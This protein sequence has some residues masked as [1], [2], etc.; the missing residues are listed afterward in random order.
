[1]KAE[2]ILEEVWRIKD[3][4]ARE[5]GGDIHRMCENARKWSAAH[6]HTGPVA[7]NAE[8][9][10]RFVAAGRTPLAGH[11]ASPPYGKDKP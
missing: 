4:L 10:R 1:M 5:A 11:E 3:D 8:E 7:R 9:L 2:S 6:P